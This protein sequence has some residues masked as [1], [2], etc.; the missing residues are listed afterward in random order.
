MGVAQ[1]QTSQDKLELEGHRGKWE[2][3]RGTLDKWEWHR[4]MALSVVFEI[5]GRGMGRW[6]V[7]WAWHMGGGGRGTN[8]NAS[9]TNSSGGQGT[10]WKIEDK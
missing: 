9:G 10:H 8:G 6:H 1:A 5:S 3:H 4:S 7:A 2:G